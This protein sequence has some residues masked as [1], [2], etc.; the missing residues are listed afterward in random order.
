MSKPNQDGPGSG[1]GYTP[2]QKAEV[3]RILKCNPKNWYEILRAA[4]TS[5]VEEARTAYNK[6]LLAVHPDKN[7]Y[8]KAGDAFKSKY[9]CSYI[10]YD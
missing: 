5:S 9:V 10:H 8:E 7:R 1:P 6:T 4:D 3:D 2:E